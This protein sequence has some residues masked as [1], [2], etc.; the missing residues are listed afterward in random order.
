MKPI[1]I[2]RKRTKGWKMPPNTKYVGRGSV[3][4]NPY[5]VKYQKCPTC[6][7]K[8]WFLF[9]TGSE[10]NGVPCKKVEYDKVIS[11]YGTESDAL[12]ACINLYRW[13]IIKRNEINIK[14]THKPYYV[15]PFISDL[16]GINLACWCKLS[17]PCHADVLL[18]LANKEE[19]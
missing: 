13:H 17:D 1:R 10:L 3:W 4:G 11:S 16:K 6:G 2:Q 12:D 19:E 14:N 5:Y 8:M 15:Y 7:N 18:E 9:D